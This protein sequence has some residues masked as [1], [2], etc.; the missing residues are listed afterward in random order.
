MLCDLI[1]YCKKN[2]FFLSAKNSTGVQEQKWDN[3]CY[4]DA[5]TCHLKG[6]TFLPTLWKSSE[7]GCHLTQC[8]FGHKNQALR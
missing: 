7:I 2:A 8:N 1:A 5:R 3:L 6:Q 4:F